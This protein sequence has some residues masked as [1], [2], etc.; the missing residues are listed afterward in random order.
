MRLLF[1]GTCDSALQNRTRRM[2][3]VRDYAPAIA[4]ARARGPLFVTRAN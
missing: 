1:F 3:L 4:A 2:T